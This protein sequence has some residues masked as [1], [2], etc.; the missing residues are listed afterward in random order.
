MAHMF[1]LSPPT[2]TNFE[3]KK[4]KRK[5]MSSPT[6]EQVRKQCFPDPSN[7]KSL[8][9]GGQVCRRQMDT[10][11]YMACSKTWNFCYIYSPHQT[12]TRRWSFGGLQLS[13]TFA[14]AEHRRP[15]SAHIKIHSTTQVVQPQEWLMQPQR[16]VRRLFF[17]GFLRNLFRRARI[18]IG[19]RCT[20][21]S[22]GLWLGLLA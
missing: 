12:E 1:R 22:A 17:L 13:I 21:G 18:F 20:R 10:H 19:V 9:R 4:R 8:L 11:M 6:K 15:A 14:S 2:Q 5:L 7:Q 3:K 16:Q